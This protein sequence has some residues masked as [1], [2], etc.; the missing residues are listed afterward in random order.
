MHDIGSLSVKYLL[1]KDCTNCRSGSAEGLKPA[2]ELYN[3]MVCMLEDQIT[4][5]INEVDW[6]SVRGDLQEL[7]RVELELRLLQKQQS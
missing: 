1:E 5:V 7:E 4:L 3:L 6:I 2:N